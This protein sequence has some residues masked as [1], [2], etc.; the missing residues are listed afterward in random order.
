MSAMD[1]RME[2][3]IRM[4]TVVDQ[5]TGELIEV[6]DS[7]ELVEK[8]LIEEGVITESTNDFLSDYFEIEERYQI[9]KEA[10]MDAMQ[11][12]NIK[13]W[14]NDYFTATVK[15]ESI[16]KRVDVE[17]MKDE[18]IYPNYIKFVTVKPSLQIRRKK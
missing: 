1:V 4:K 17:R 12:N 8:T 16:Q 10:L 15:D 3:D 6:E 9:F 14:S 18:G 13:S 2:V 7:N 5:E 11:K